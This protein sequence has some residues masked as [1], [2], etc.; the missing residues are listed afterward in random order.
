MINQIS[1]HISQLTIPGAT[2]LSLLLLGIVSLIFNSSY[3]DFVKIL[4]LLVIFG[5]FAFVLTSAKSSETTQPIEK[6]QKKWELQK[7]FIPLL[8]CYNA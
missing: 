5:L 6:S 7:Y 1:D 8:H 3:P 4:I 2:G